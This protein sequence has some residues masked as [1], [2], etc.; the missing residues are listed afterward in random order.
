MDKDEIFAK[1]LQEEEEK[2][3]ELLQLK[4]LH[5][6]S[7]SLEL[8]LKLQAEDYLRTKENNNA[9]EILLTLLIKFL[10]LLQIKM[11]YRNLYFY[12]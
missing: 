3:L 6:E 12:E 2:E 8:A 11:I 5:E 10:K 7:D 4:R 1:K 9:G